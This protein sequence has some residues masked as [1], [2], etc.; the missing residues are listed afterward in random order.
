MATHPPIRSTQAAEVARVDASW[1]TSGASHRRQVNGQD[2]QQQGHRDDVLAIVLKDL[3]KQPTMAGAE[4][5]EIARGDQPSG[6]VVVSMHSADG[7][8]DTGQAGVGQAVLP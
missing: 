1:R 2:A 7:S 5:V 4:I 8:L 3:A 6:Q